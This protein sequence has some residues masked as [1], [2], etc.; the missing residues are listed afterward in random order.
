[1]IFEP[2]LPP[3]DSMRTAIAQ[4]YRADEDD[5]VAALLSQARLGLEADKRI[6]SRAQKL[7]AA[8]REGR[9]G[10]G[11]ID[12]FLQEYELSSQEGVVLQTPSLQIL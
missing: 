4:A 11:G 6:A 8:V 1:M 9:Q 2:P 7:V 10:A 5:C 12:A 3:W